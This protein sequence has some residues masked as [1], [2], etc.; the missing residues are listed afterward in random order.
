[1]SKPKA[2]GFWSHPI[3]YTKKG[4][5][6]VKN[7]FKPGDL[8]FEVSHG[9]GVFLTRLSE[10][11]QDTYEI[12][13]QVMCYLH[14]GRYSTCAVLPS[15]FH[16]TPEMREKLVA[17][18]G[19]DAVPKLPVRGSELTKKLLEKQKYVFCLVSDVSD[20]DA[21]KHSML[22]IIESYTIHNWFSEAGSGLYRYA[23]PIDNNGDEITEIESC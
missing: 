11:V 21:R 15:L 18:W 10:T 7:E 16:A 3:Y 23:V 20:E 12:R 8:V 5:A 17:I 19:E 4:A 6:N 13:G 9:E 14:D 1:M 22:A 2:Y